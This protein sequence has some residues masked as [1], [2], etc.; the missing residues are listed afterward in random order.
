MQSLIQSH[1]SSCRRR[2]ACDR[3]GGS[4]PGAHNVWKLSVGWSL[5][6]TKVQHTCVI[7]KNYSSPPPKKKQ[8]ETNHNHYR[9]VAKCKSSPLC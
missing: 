9:F 2:P 3:G 1:F 6:E 5:V 7:F 4:G 8:F